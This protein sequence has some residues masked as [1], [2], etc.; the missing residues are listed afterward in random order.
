MICMKFVL[1]YVISNYG[2]IGEQQK[3]NYIN[4]QMSSMLCWEVS[5]FPWGKDT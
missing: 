4:N 2:P 3:L 1:K 5:V